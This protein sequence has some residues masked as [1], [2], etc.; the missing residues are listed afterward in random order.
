LDDRYSKRDKRN[1]KDMGYSCPAL[2]LPVEQAIELTWI[3][4][5]FVHLLQCDGLVNLKRNTR[6]TDYAIGV[7][8]MR[9]SSQVDPLCSCIPAIFVIYQVSD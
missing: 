2:P 8:V 5:I 1:I 6:T 3:Q 4:E 7:L 9:H